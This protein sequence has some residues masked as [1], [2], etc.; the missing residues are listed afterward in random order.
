MELVILIGLQASGKST[1]FQTRFANTHVHISKDLMRNNKNRRRRQSQLLVEALAAGQSVVVDN[2]NPTVA[3]RADLIQQGQQYGAE[4]IGYY[5]ESTLSKCLDR[6]QQR[7]GKAK[8]PE[9][10]LYATI[11][12]LVKP[13]YA[14]GFD[15]LFHVAI[16]AGNTFR[17]QAW[18]EDINDG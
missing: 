14:E 11:K 16:A 4:I 5:F 10:G 3:E 12:K 7:A 6:N 8:I 13:T 17:V 1:F 2:T 9:V 18:Q 15:R